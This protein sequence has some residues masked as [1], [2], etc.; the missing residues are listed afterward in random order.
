MRYLVNQMTLADIP[1]VVEI[2]KLAYPSTWPASSYRK[3]LQDNP[4]AHYIVERDTK[5]PIEAGGDSP[6]DSGR[7]PFPLSLLARPPAPLPPEIAN[8]VGF[9][10]LWLMVD[11]A[12]VTTIATHPDYRHRGLGELLLTALIDIAYDIGA[13]QVTLEARVSNTVAQN[14]YRKYGF[15][16][17]GHSAALLQRQPGRRAH[18]VDRR[19]HV[20]SLS[21]A[22]FLLDTA[23]CGAAGRRGEQ[24]R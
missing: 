10:G 14:L 19:H 8:I 5:M 21:R 2:E 18:H 23:T 9:A 12:H 3:E 17:A 15:R 16:E 4:L 7:R 22:V 11:E 1:R 6:S 13:R 20:E 24:R